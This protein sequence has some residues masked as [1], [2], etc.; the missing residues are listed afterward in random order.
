MLAITDG[1]NAQP[2]FNNDPFNSLVK[3][4]WEFAVV[5]GMS[6]QGRLVP[7]APPVLIDPYYVSGL[8]LKASR[9]TLTNFAVCFGAS[10]RL[11]DLWQVSNDVRELQLS[12]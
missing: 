5:T 4:I 2:I 9:C 10:Q 8:L 6:G 3:N 11:W 1:A 7:S 12:D